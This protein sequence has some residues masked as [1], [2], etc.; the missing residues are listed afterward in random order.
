MDVIISLLVSAIGAYFG[1]ID[2]FVLHTIVSLSLSLYKE[3][4]KHTNDKTA[5]Q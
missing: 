1:G 5:S 2:F 3:W 4:L